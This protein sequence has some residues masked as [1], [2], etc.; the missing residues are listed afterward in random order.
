[1]MRRELISTHLSGF[2]L[3]ST[4]HRRLRSYTLTN[5]KNTMPSDRIKVLK[6]LT[7]FAVGGTERQ[8]VYTATGLDRSRFDIRVGC[9][10]QIGP[11]MKDIR[12]LNVPIWEYPIN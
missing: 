1:M 8:F 12:A 10:A 7:H 4:L 11:F 2:R 6:F 5:R 3:A 9:T